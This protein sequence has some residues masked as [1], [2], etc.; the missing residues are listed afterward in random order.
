MGVETRGSF[1]PDGEVYPLASGAFDFQ[2]LHR[3]ILGLI[4]RQGSS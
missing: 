4:S 1:H 3:R 2:D